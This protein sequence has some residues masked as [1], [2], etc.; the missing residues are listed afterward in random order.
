LAG[1][2]PAPAAAGLFGEARSAARQAVAR[3]AGQPERETEIRQRLCFYEEGRP[4]HAGKP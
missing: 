3:A 1:T 2:E 4:F